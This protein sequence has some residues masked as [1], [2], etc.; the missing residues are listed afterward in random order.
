MPDTPLTL[1]AVREAAEHHARGWHSPR[2]PV[3]I[4]TAE[5][6]SACAMEWPCP[7]EIMYRL[8]R[9]VELVLEGRWS[10]HLNTDTGVW[11]VFDM[12]A[13]ACLAASTDALTALSEAK[14]AAEAGGE[15]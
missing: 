1:E 6:C 5:R 2:K 10:L 4:A 8:T 3:G 14:R 11:R 15:S 13:Y 9:L 12:P 7:T